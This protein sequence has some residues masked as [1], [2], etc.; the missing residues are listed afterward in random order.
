MD[1][2]QVQRLGE[3]LA[4]CVG[5]VFASLGY[6][7]GPDRAGHYLRGLTLDGRRKSIQPMAARLHGPHEQAL[8]HFITNSP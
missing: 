7:G 5:D 4:E 8:N 2:A 6:S 1:I 3:D